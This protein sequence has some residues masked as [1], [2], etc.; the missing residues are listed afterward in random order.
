MTTAG[1]S[2]SHSTRWS[3]AAPDL[4]YL[5]PLLTADIRSVRP[6]LALRPARPFGPRVSSAGIRCAVPVRGP[7]R[8]LSVGACTTHP[9]QLPR[10]ADAP[11]PCCTAGALEPRAAASPM[12]RACRAVP[13]VPER[14][15]WRVEHLSWSSFSRPEG[16]ARMQSS[17]DL[18]KPL[19]AHCSWWALRGGRCPARWSRRP[20]WP[21][22]SSWPRSSSQ[23][24]L[25]TSETCGWRFFDAGT[26]GPGARRMRAEP[27]PT[28]AKVPAVL[29]AP[30]SD[31]YR[32]PQ[33][34]RTQP[35]GGTGHARPVSQRNPCSDLPGAPLRSVGQL[36]RPL[37]T[38]T[39]HDGR[40]R[41][42][43]PTG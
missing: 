26:G 43:A 31:L 13:C 22:W 18:P 24:I 30:G 17:D 8:R 16:N 12:G 7:R 6:A 36:V 40:G 25:S 20:C 37:S 19:R 41:R 32:G 29:D 38:A 21:L 33:A 11:S 42:P 4:P 3:A 15:G 39:R 35:A 5:A 34:A 2:S 10:A 27:A 9:S 1:V 23:R 14:F 28:G